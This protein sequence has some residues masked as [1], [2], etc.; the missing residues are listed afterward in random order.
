MIRVIKTGDPY[1]EVQA[2]FTL[3]Y[4][5]ATLKYMNMLL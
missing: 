2:Y 1:T 3:K 4:M 5:C